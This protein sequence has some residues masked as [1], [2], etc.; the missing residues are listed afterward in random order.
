[1]TTDG[2]VTAPM[3][4]I[5]TNPDWGSGG[6]P[7]PDRPS[8]RAATTRRLG[9]SHGARPG[10]REL[11]GTLDERVSTLVPFAKRR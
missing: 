7:T 3:G 11:S 1:M 4:R 5:V 8:G 6:R 10:S 9:T 2:Q